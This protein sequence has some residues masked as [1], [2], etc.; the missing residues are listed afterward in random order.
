MKSN[1]IFLILLIFLAAISISTVSAQDIATNE[2]FD[3]ND[4]QIDDSVM[5]VDNTYDDFGVQSTDLSATEI[6]AEN[7]SSYYQDNQ[8]YSV[9]LVE[10][11]GTAIAGENITFYSGNEILGKNLTD[12]NGIANIIHTFTPGNYTIDAIFG[13]ND[14]YLS[15]EA[16]MNV[17][18]N[19]TIISEDVVKYYKNGTQFYA[20]LLDNNGNPLPEGTLVNVSI[21]GKTYG[22][23][24]DENSSVTLAINLNP[25]K[26]VVTVVNPVTNQTSFYNVTVLS[27]ISGNNIVKYYKNG[28]Q[29]IVNCLDAKGN[30]LANENVTFNIIGKVYS[31][32]TD[33]NGTAIL[34]INLIPGEYVVTVINPVDGLMHSNN[35]SVLSNIYGNNIVKYYKNDTQYSATFL[36]AQGNPLANENVTFNIIGKIYSLETDEN[37]T[38][39]LPINLNPGKYIITVTNPINGLMYSNN[40][41]VLS[42]IDGNDT[43]I[44]YLSGGKY[45]CRILDKQGNPVPKATVVFNII[46]K[47]YTITADENGTASLPINLLPGTYTITTSYNGLMYSNKITVSKAD[48]KIAFITTSIKSGGTLQYK[49]TNSATGQPVA[50]MKT[51]LY[52]YNSEFE[53]QQGWYIYTDSSGVASIRMT[54]NAGNYYMGAFIPEDDAYYAETSIIT[55]ITVTA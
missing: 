43:T 14:I 32:E 23:E 4:L 1:K 9:K 36:D 15:S 54:A 10:D 11:N 29:Y 12:E 22:I 34:P 18:I 26:Y 45:T 24:T 49:V 47:V 39:T 46:G 55:Q 21:I 35:I 7:T 30:P 5:T 20:I 42:F 41:T 13:G 6:I 44:K 31:L 19:S 40:I 2:N 3:N 17:E 50:G 28:T 51:I 8:Q 48:A 33:E 16:T 37:G 25:G 52:Y 27:T 38:A 53:P